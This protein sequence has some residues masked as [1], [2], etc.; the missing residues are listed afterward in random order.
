MLI[1]FITDLHTCAEGEFPHN[2]DLRQ[3][4]LDI[5]RA[6]S[7][8]NYDF[9]V[10]GGDLCFS[11]G[12][13]DIYRWQKHYLDLLKKPYFIIPGNHDDQILLNQ[14]FPQFALTG[15]SEIYYQYQIREKTILFLDTARGFTSK[16]QKT[17]L[18]SQLQR[19]NNQ[20]T[21]IFMHHPP[22]LMQVPH[23]D[24]KYALQDRD[25]ILGILEETP[26]QKDLF[27]GHYHVSKHG[28][29]D[30][31]SIHITPSLFFQIDQ[32]DEDFAVDD[33]RIGYR[34]IRITD[35]NVLSSV[36]YLNGNLRP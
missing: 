21:T 23:M 20:R 22:M 9:L 15:D 18:R 36:H 3:N 16:T 17:W 28:S 25:E 33:L 4:F 6:T 30:Q 1:L 24:K 7:R 8:H 32:F 26:G 35:Q 27:C 13:L 19:L 34:L 31:V 14:V 11:D 12:N 29:K 10:V 5:L 2:I